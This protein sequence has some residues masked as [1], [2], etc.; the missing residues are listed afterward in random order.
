MAH[1]CLLYVPARREP[2]DDAAAC[3]QN[4]D[5]AALVEVIRAATRS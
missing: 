4:F 3:D 5:P 1:G 2:L